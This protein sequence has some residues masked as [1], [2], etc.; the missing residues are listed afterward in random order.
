MGNSKK[1][2]LYSTGEFAELCG[3]KKQTLFHYD[4]IG[5]LCPETVEDNGYRRYSY[6]QY[7]TFL[8]IS[9]LKEANM[10]LAEI[11]DFLEEEDEDKKARIVQARISALDQRIAYLMNVRK[12]LSNSFSNLGMTVGTK[13]GNTDE[14]RLENRPEIELWKSRPL[15]LMDDKE[16]VEEVARI[17]KRVEPYGVCLASADI[18][19]G[20]YDNQR[21]LLVMKQESLSDE[22]AHELGLSTYK[23]PAGRYGVTD[24]Q[25]GEDAEDVYKRLLQS[26]KDFNEIPGEFFFEEYPLEQGRVDGA[27]LRIAVQLIPQD[28]SP[29]H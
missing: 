16:L 14:I 11:K 5:L 26:M 22:E 20:I 7:E 12:I 24:Q 8:L 19:E 3:V 9:C 13:E 10:S 18:A 25:S 17:V 27:P 21:H 6:N 1:K 2:L 23:R 29:W 28:D 4:E 15:N